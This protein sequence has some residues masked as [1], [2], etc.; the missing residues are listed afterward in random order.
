M[1]FFSI[2]TEWSLVVCLSLK[3]QPWFAESALNADILPD[4]VTAFSPPVHT[5]SGLTLFICTIGTLPVTDCN[6][7][8]FSA[9]VSTVFCVPSSRLAVAV[10]DTYTL[11]AVKSVCGTAL[12]VYF[13]VIISLPISSNVTVSSPETISNWLLSTVILSIA[14]LSITA[15]SP[16]LSIST[17]TSNCP[18]FLYVFLSSES[19]TL[20]AVI[21]IWVASSLSFEK[22]PTP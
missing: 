7:T 22:L 8:F 21:F 10:S 9:A 18:S 15:S 12:N 3:S 11:P 17:V 20:P 19:S 13:F 4:T 16:V 14:E 2:K 5:V 1:F 6:I